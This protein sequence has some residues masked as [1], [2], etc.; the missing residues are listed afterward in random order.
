[1]TLIHAVLLYYCGVVC[2]LYLILGGYK[3]IRNYIQKKIEQ[4][5]EAKISPGK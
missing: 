3:V 4:A 2:T 5:A 1:M